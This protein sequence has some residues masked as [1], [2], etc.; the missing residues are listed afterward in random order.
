MRL[1]L[2]WLTVL[3]LPESS[4]SECDIRLLLNTSNTYMGKRI[5][6]GRARK[7]IQLQTHPYAINYVTSAMEPLKKQQLLLRVGCLL[8]TGHPWR[9]CFWNNSSTSALTCWEGLNR[10]PCSGKWIG[11]QNGLVAESYSTT[12]WSSSSALTPWFTQG[13]CRS[14]TLDSVCSRKTYQAPLNSS[15]R[16]LGYILIVIFLANV[17]HPFRQMGFPSRPNWV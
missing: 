8:R 17:F 9:S 4:I 6:S 15:N 16:K 14:S 13:Y 5:E 7:N 3:S 10:H 11:Q 2:Q 12:L 1:C